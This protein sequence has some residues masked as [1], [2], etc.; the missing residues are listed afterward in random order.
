MHGS[1]QYEYKTLNRKR[2]SKKK[3]KKNTEIRA[4]EVRVIGDDGTQYGVIPFQDALGL[5][6]EKNMDLVEVSPLADPPVCKIM[7]FGRLQYEQDRQQ[8]KAKSMSKR[9][10]ELKGIRLSVTIGDHDLGVRVKNGQKFL[11]KGN[12]LKIELQLRGRQKAH[13]ELAK[14]T[15]DRYIE[16]LERNTVVE[17]PVKR[18]GGRFSAIVST[19]KN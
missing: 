17:Q 7:D 3:F 15:I 1:P 16:L 12:K 5:A 2:I 4:E 6:G 19:K 8:R 13:P 14:E 10:G 9:A 11:D 18:Q